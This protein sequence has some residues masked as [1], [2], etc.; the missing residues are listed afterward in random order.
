M[1]IKRI[2]K[3]TFQKEFDS[4]QMKREILRK[5][6]SKKSEWRFRLAVSLSMV[7]VVFLSAV[8]FYKETD[9]IYINQLQYRNDISRLNSEVEQSISLEEE[10]IFEL[11]VGKTLP[12]DFQK[13]EY[14]KV[15]TKTQT[16]KDIV[17]YI[18]QSFGK[19]D[20]NIEITLSEENDLSRSYLYGKDI[21]TSKV[22][23]IE[24]AI[25]QYQDF[26]VTTFFSQGY[27]FDIKAYHMNKDEFVTLL[28]SILKNMK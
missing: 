28:K 6:E 23:G 24:V 10:S 9:K 15:I 11:L 26:Y 16:E 5:A 12:R 14:K 22:K 18:Y 4:E 21:K 27:Y 3:E 13:E 8:F 1:T 19:D 25:Y 7:C 17:K 20:R 2:I